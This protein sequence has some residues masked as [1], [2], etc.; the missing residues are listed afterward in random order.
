M[1]LWMY[2]VDTKDHI[3]KFVCH[4]LDFWLNFKGVLP[5]MVKKRDRQTNIKHKLEQ[6]K[7]G[8]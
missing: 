4:Y 1:M 5:T 6:A 8:L 7:P 2:L 3:L